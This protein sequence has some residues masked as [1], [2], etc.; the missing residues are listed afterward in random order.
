M[1][2]RLGRRAVLAGLVGA[3]VA[4]ASLSPVRGYL[5][6]F[7]PLSGSVWQTARA[8]R[9][10]EVESPYGTAEL[11]YDKDGV[12]HVSADDEGALYFAVGYAQGSD[13]LFQ[14]DFQRRL[15]AGELS[16]V[17]GELTVASDRFHRQMAFTDAAEATAEHIDGTP[18][19]AAVDAFADGVNAAIENE[20]L[21]L[22]CQ[23]L[24]YEPEPW[25][26]ADTAL[27]EKLIAWQL[28]GS[29]RT[30]RV[31]LVRER[32]G[33][34]LSPERADELVGELFP[35]R[36]DHDAPIIREHHDAGEFRVDEEDGTGS[37]TTDRLRGAVSSAQG[38]ADEVSSYRRTETP[39]KELVDWLGRFESPPGTGSNS[40]LIG[41]EHTAGDAPILA[42][43]PHLSLQAPPTWYE[44]H[45]DGPDHRARGVAFPGTPLV[46]I[47]ENDHGA[48]GFTNA[49]ADVI[50]F[51]SY[52]DDGETYA[53]GDERREFE[54]E[55]QKIAVAGGADE[56]VEVT[57]TVH[58]PVVEEADQRVGVAWTGHAATETIQ[59]L[60]ELS[61]STGFD[62]ALAAAERFESPTQNLLYA[63]RE[64][65]TLYYMTG[66][67]PLRQVDGERAPGDRVFDG[68]APEG[69]WEG[70]EPF[71]RPTW[72]GFVPF[73]SNP[74]V[75]DPDYLA[76]ANQQIVD[77]D[78]LDY[79]LSQGYASPYR[80][81]RL[82]ER[83][84]ER[85]DSGEPVDLEFLRDVGRDSYDGRAAAL[86]E[87]LVEAARDGGQRL[88]EAAGI[89]DAWEYRL[90][91]DSR[92]A[93]IFDRWFERYREAL[94]GETFAE[95]DLDETYYPPAAAIVQLPR[96]SGWFGSRGRAQIMREALRETL[97]ELET[98]GH[99]RYGDVNH[100]GHIAHPLEL[101]FLGYPE[102]PRGGGGETVW[103]YSRQGPWG[104]SWEM[105]ADLDGELLGILPGGNSGRYFSAHYRDQLR[106]WAD[107][108][109]RSLS[110]E[111]EGELTTEFVSGER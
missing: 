21:P 57:K 5:E 107:G 83:L 10:E 61:H 90:A 38:V 13:R 88:R 80:G 102:H 12:P 9:Q 74:H 95:A 8:S 54:H 106:A 104:G 109:Y 56:T 87:P 81:A 39:G 68:S 25:S 23:L 4:G 16:A 108:E 91:A 31:A 75:L 19:A 55:S 99:D 2:G 24:D 70:F 94:L 82:Y 101:G 110:R 42:N 105:Q 11:R 63:D 22:E 28:T 97:A 35:A 52:D 89:L 64:G 65:R 47:G 36:F 33:A 86:V 66:R 98:E 40:W 45:L 14:M 100:T 37:T 93:L 76:T 67:L 29:F 46:V 59:S 26:R 50:D 71:G 53:Y 72:E 58:G 20:P 92:A 43:D 1:N 48:W 85:I 73:D 51:Y 15:F 49:G 103:N 32:L 34:L 18:A 60:Y 27:I 30:L 17:V 44:M 96:D 77:D 84:D 41:A 6:Q 79:Y 111:V 78:R 69:E 7:A 62:D 3:G